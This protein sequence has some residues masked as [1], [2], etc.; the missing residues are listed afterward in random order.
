MAK[1]IDMTV[2]AVEAVQIP[3][4]GR[5]D[6]RD[7][8]TAGL[9][10]RVSSTGVRTF[11]FVG[12]AKGS[13]RVERVTLGKYPAVRPDEA[14]R[15][16]TM[17]GGEL[18]SG[19]SAA[20]AVRG[21]RDELTLRS[22]A[23][24]YLASLKRRGASSGSPQTLWDLYVNSEFG[25]RRMSEISA[26]A[27]ERWHRA[28]P[29][30][31]LQRRSAKQA[32][33]E[34]FKAARRAAVVAAQA[35]RRRGPEPK[36]KLPTT[37]SRKVTGLSTANQALVLVGTI[38]NWAAD[39]KR[40]YYIGLNPATGHDMFSVDSRERFLRPD[41]LA[42]FFA[43]LAA[44]P[45]ETMRDFIVLALLTGAR[46]SNVAAMAW[47]DVDPEHAEWHVAGERMKNGMPQTITLTPEAVEILRAR[48]V[49][50][51]PHVFPSSK[52]KSGHIADPR[53]AWERVLRASG[54]TDL[55]L[56][57]LRRTLGSW[58]ARTGASLLLIG[59]SLNHKDQAS[60]AIYARLD[61]DPVRQSVDRATSA[62]FEAA[63]VKPKAAVIALEPKARDRNR[64]INLRIQK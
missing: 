53:K 7:S 32:E 15:R 42:P 55:R 20:A 28:L 9:Y 21:K 45:N 41:E 14:R 33:R 58:Q 44:E 40:A 47:S 5:T 29:E 27:L 43:A 48:M 46:R 17:L 34:A 10:L 4:T 3:A 59:K 26:L 22:V 64:V 50:K 51:S 49:G 8:K 31:I 25:S 1:I 13:S 2:K 52:A 35:G 56:H 62:M 12:R 39:A 63:G 54:L 37:S 30:K 38:F 16:A 36:A 24:L 11:S 18:A 61:L 57:D 19:T 60:T 23:E 6:Y